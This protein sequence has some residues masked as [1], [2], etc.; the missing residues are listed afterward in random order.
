MGGSTIR[1]RKLYFLFEQSMLITV[2]IEISHAPELQPGLGI[3][4]RIE[5]HHP[6]TVRG[7]ECYEGDVMLLRHGVVDGI[8]LCET[9]VF[10]VESRYLRCFK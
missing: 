10:R 5:L 8:Q 2:V 9:T 6:E 1:N 4:L 7:N 3:A